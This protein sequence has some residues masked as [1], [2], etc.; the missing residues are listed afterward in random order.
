MGFRWKDDRRT[1][2]IF[3]LME[4]KTSQGRTGPVK[5]YYTRIVGPFLIQEK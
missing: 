4:D 3:S 2:L 1:P 5:A